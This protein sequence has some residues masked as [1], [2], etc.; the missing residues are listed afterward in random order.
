MMNL[1]D[2]KR[3]LLTV[4]ILMSISAPV[5]AAQSAAAQDKTIDAGQTREVVVTATRTEEEVKAVPSAVEVI[6]QEDIQQLGATDVYSA[7][8]L[9]SNLDVTSAGMAGH[10]VMIRGMSTNHTLILIDGKRT[11][12]EDTSVTQNVY[13]L[14][15]LSLSNIERIEIVR[16]T[17][18]AQ[19]GSDALGGVINIITKKSEKPSVT[20]GV[21]TGTESVNNYYHFDFGK[22]GRFSSTF[23]MRFSDLRKNMEDGDEGSNYYGP[24]QDFNFSGTYDLTKDKKLDLTLGYYNEH[25]KADYADSFLDTIEV[26]GKQI[27][28]NKWVNR[29]KAEWY[30]YK[31]YDISLGYSGKTDSGDYMLRT[32]YS[33]LDKENN[34]YNNRE[35]LESITMPVFENGKPVIQNGR[36]VFTT[37]EASMGAMYPKYDWDKSTYTLWGVE[38]RNSQQIDDHNLLTFGAEYRRNSVE[39]TRMGDGGD[40]VHNVEQNGIVKQYSEKDVT[41]YAMYVQDE[42]MP[43]EKW[44]VIPS[45]RYDHDSS[46]GGELTPKIGATYFIKDNSRLKFNLGKGFKAPTISELYMNMHRAMGI[47]TVNVYGNPDLQPEESTSWDISYEAELNNNW[48]KLTYFNNDI[49][50]LIDTENINNSKFDARYVNIGK[51]QINGVELELGRHLNDNW[52]VKATSNWLDAKN[53]ITDERL[54]NRAEN[55]TTLQLIYD[56]NNVNGYSAVLWQQWASNYRYSNADYDWTTT[57]FSVNKK[58]GE[59]NRIYAGVDN[60]FDKKISDIN[61]DG[62]IWRAGVEFTF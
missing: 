23:D 47:G 62:M 17:A 45:L 13:A 34:L 9:A 46:F 27:P 26:S 37:M 54:G 5:Y 20:V 60:I 58:F 50:N 25:T 40:N 16:G 49:K 1:L 29:D 7:L 14:D 19:Y 3:A 36:P 42:W 59:G 4:S 31:R 53:E 33:R 2:K 15:R 52:T 48:G 28:I 39:G 55:M 61:L 30:D 57:N 32:Y 44:L 12:G 21:S 24:V 18:S 6:T 22:Q 43:N 56:D 8:R 51:A 41:N 10:N 11:A 35:S 38:G